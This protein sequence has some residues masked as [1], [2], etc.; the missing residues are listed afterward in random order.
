MDSAVLDG[1]DPDPVSVVVTPANPGSLIDA[2]VRFLGVPG[3]GASCVYIVEVRR[4]STAN[5][6]RPYYVLRLMG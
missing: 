4:T 3:S 6:N 2:I 5:L 1:G